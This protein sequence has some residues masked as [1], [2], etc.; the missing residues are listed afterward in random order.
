MTQQHSLS[1]YHGSRTVLDVGEIQ[2]KKY[3]SSFRLVHILS[4]WSLQYTLWLWDLI[5]LIL[6]QH[7]SSRHQDT[8]IL[9]TSC[10]DNLLHVSFNCFI[11]SAAFMLN[12]T[13]INHRLRIREL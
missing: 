8:Q 7:S 3:S 13:G 4:M 11:L 1:A 9:N 5:L 12:Y 10:T 6:K 2:I